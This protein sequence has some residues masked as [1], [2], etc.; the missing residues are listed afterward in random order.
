MTPRQQENFVIA[1]DYLLSLVFVVGM[2]A[3]IMLLG[4]S[5]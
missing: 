4:E 3:L 2:V 1:T 5:F